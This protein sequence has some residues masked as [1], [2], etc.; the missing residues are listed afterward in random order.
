MKLPIKG[1]L[2]REYDVIVIGGGPAG[3]AAAIAAKE[4]GANKVLVLER[5]E[6][7]GGFLNQVI[8]NGFYTK[9]KDAELTAPEYA[10]K[11]IDRLEELNIHYILNC[12]VIDITKNMMVTAVSEE[13]ILEMK[14]KAVVFAMGSREKPRGTTN[15][16]GSRVSGIF[17]AGSAQNIINIDGYMP[18][19]QV[20]IIGSGDTGLILARRMTMEG[21]TIK[22]VIEILPYAVGSEKNVEEC[23]EDFG[24]SLKLGYTV[25]DIKGKDRVEGLLI[26]K[27]DSSNIPIEGTEEHIACDTIV[28][29]VGLMPENELPAKIGAAIA[30]STRGLIVDCNMQTNIRGIFACGDVLY[31]HEYMEDVTG[32]SIRAGRSAA[33]FFS[34]NQKPEN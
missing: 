29:T 4:E 11:L 19:K 34:L 2:M 22:G 9:G 7:L 6:Q 1:G 5:E 25:V 12:L 15:I 17:T 27:V 24:I 3:L 13:G 21:A 32:E 14:A 10:Q 8:H 20:A 31:V 23:L 30:P 28:V 33:H 16:P 18:G 26:A